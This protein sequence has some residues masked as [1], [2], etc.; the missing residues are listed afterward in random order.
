MLDFL[1]CCMLVMI[2]KKVQVPV[3]RE[4]SVSSYHLPVSIQHRLFN[5]KRK[6][7][8][9][10]TVKSIC[11][12]IGVTSAMEVVC[13]FLRVVSPFRNPHHPKVS[14]SPYFYFKDNPKMADQF[15]VKN[16]FMGFGLIIMITHK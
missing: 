13:Y 7:S 12:Q 9:Y 11:R 6:P 1:I 8:N 3:K 16:I 15:M 4:H 2:E 10:Q 14:S 5:E